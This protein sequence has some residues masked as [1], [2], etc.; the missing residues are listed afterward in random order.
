MAAAR[1]M[2]PGGNTAN[3]FHSFYQYL[4][5]ADARH[6]FVIK[7][8]PGTGK[9]TLMKNLG[10]KLEQQGLAVEYHWCSSDNG[11]LDGMVVPEYLLAVVDGTAPHVVDP[12][13]PGAVDEI[14][15]LG[16]CWDRSAMTGAR[17]A[18]I[19]TTSRISFQFEL[20]YSRLA[21]TAAA[22]REW[23][24]CVRRALDQ[25]RINRVSTALEEILD[26][27]E[28]PVASMFK[29]RHLF[30]SA[31]TPGGV[32]THL[33]TL[34]TKETR[35]VALEGSPGCGADEL[36]AA[37]GQRAELLGYVIEYYHCPLDPSAI[38]SL[39][40]PGLDLAVVNLARQ[41]VAPLTNHV[42]GRTDVHSVNL[43]SHLKQNDLTPYKDV[44]E[45]ARGRFLQGLIETVTRLSRAKALH[46]ELETHY[47]A[48]M[49]FTAVT[50]Q[51]ERLYT[52]ILAQCR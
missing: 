52:D 51:R 49:D 6:K 34:W 1:M 37:L 48:A 27:D 42:K 13:F 24:K 14:V 3:G 5:P 31:I 46:D 8:G 32:V 35:V 7:G 9:S 36:M 43:D 28:K 21:E 10:E 23:E 39:Y 22:Y 11:S 38:E 41:V 2:F 12:V 19:D 16:E 30:A 40:C 15:N 29:T 18:V 44:I 17:Q 45:H 47:V 26:G 50:R 33:P 20:V 4:V 25:G